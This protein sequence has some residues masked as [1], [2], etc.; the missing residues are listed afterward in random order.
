M[1]IRERTDDAR[2]R[3][4][5]ALLIAS[6]CLLGLQLA[7]SPAM[8]QKG[9]TCGQDSDCKGKRFLCYEKQCTRLKKSEAVIRVRVVFP[10]A[11]GGSVYIDGTY[12]GEGP[13]EG[14]IEPGDHEVRVEAKRLL[15]YVKMIDCP[16]RQA[17]VV[18]VSLQRDPAF[19]APPPPPPQPVSEPTSGRPKMLF[20]GVYGGGGIGT[21][22]W[23]EDNTRRP[24]AKWQV[25]G[26]V[27]ARL[28]EDPLWLDLAAAISYSSF[29]VKDPPGA[30]PS[31]LQNDWT[32]PDLGAGAQFAVQARLLFPIEEH[33]FYLGGEI[34]PGYVLSEARYAYVT[35][36]PTASLFF[37]EWVEV[38][39]SPVGLHWLQE[40][41]GAGFV[42]ALYGTVGVVVRFYEP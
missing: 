41:T 2:R 13:W 22:Q 30:E 11:V 38:R 28:L 5:A 6:S 29:R 23:G 1:H 39:V 36:C 10:G 40:L 35:L 27:G 26:A 17:T 4:S 15:P 31:E 9:K 33:F 18:D 20:A 32:P 19:D 34:E 42:A 21:A 24:A 8:A 12:R 25:G 37:G 3:F 16:A 14:V 7:A